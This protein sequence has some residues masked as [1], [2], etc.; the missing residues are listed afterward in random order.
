M[1]L[2][3]DDIEALRARLLASRDVLLQVA[4]ANAEAGATVTLDPAREGR[5]SRMDALQGQAMATA[6][7]QR[8][9]HELAR[10]A[11]ALQRV[12]VGGYGECIEC[13]EAVAPGRL[14]ADPAATHCIEC[15]SAAERGSR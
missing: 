1:T 3:H 8:R 9:R 4:D 11:A 14:R 15:A 7:G 13:G 12:D 5:L 10:I 6:A 2:S